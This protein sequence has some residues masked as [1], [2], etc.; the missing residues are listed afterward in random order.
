MELTVHGFLFMPDFHPPYDWPGKIATIKLIRALHIAPSA[1]T[2]PLL[3]AKYAAEHPETALD[4]FE[5]NKT[6]NGAFDDGNCLLI[7]KRGFKITTTGVRLADL[8][9]GAVMNTDANM[10]AIVAK[11]I[12]KYGADYVVR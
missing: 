12:R 1:D 6:L 10:M 7:I 9:L 2:C 8:L 5:R 11:A 3:D 4:Y